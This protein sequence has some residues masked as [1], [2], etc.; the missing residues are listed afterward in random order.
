MTEFTIA[1]PDELIPAIMA[2]YL[3]VKA[4]N[5]TEASSPEEY[6]STSVVEIVRQRA[7]LLKVGPYF[8]GALEP[9][10]LA[11]GMPNPA[12]DGPDAIVLPVETEEE[13]MGE[14]L[15]EGADEEE[16]ES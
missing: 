11:D 15:E 4:A 3:S 12:Y 5:A 14:M 10:F 8:K 16:G 7:E 1:I 13:A 6:F 9:R 2:E